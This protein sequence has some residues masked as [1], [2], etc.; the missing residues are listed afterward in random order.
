[1]NNTTTYIDGDVIMYRSAFSGEIQ[2]WG[3]QEA[4][5]NVYVSCSSRAKAEEIQ[6][7]S[8][9]L[10][11]TT[12]VR[13]QEPL[14]V[15]MAQR[16]LENDVR[17]IQNNTGCAESVIYLS[18]PDRTKNDRYKIAKTVPYKGN[19]KTLPPLHKEAMF[20]YLCEMGSIVVD[21]I[22]A[23]DAL[24]TALNNDSNG[25]CASIDKD[26]LMIPGKHYNIVSRII[27]IA[28][29]PGALALE[30]TKS[31]NKLRGTGFKWFCAQMLMGDPVDN[32]KGLVGYGDVKAFKTLDS[33]SHIEDMYRT[34][35]N[36]YIM[37]GDGILRF[38]ENANLLWIRRNEG[39][40]F[41]N[42]VDTNLPH[43]TNGVSID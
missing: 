30:K 43:V 26:L 37:S 5:G 41:T 33:V 25:V 36:H 13:T 8:T 20:N 23:D 9:L 21:G 6:S 18:H 40:T 17:N 29:D 10:R 12:I 39:E 42:W 24:G 28:S 22:E 19:R 7:K 27:T 31:S 2:A 16:N 3:L 15:R 11:D 34:V 38:Y 32:I 1:M 35:K 4:D 14:P